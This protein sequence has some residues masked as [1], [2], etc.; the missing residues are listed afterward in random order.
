M[1]QYHILIWLV[2]VSEISS[3]CV[4]HCNASSLRG[5]LRLGVLN[6]AGLADHTESAE[7]RVVLALILFLEEKQRLSRTAPR[8]THPWWYLLSTNAMVDALI[9][10][11]HVKRVSVGSL[12]PSLLEHRLD[13]SSCGSTLPCRRI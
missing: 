12:P 5:R 6:G 10:R 1:R 8:E 13:R 3:S 11:Y 4:I 2:R 9:Y 7:P